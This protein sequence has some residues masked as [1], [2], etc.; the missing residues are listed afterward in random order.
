[1]RTTRPYTLFPLALGRPR[2]DSS[3]HQW[4]STAPAIKASFP[5]RPEVRLR[6]RRFPGE[7]LAKQPPRVNPCL[8]R[9]LE[10]VRPAPGRVPGAMNRG[11][12]AAASE[13]LEGHRDAIH[14]I[15][16]TGRRW[17]I[18]EH[19]AEVASASAAQNFGANHAQAGI[20]AFEHRVVDGLPEARPSGATV[21][22]GF[23]GVEVQRAARAA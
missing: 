20:W 13:R 16:Q 14:A 2:S 4:R 10:S 18:V 21:E 15:A 7:C 3:P 22:L 1:M 6:R 23:R 11:F 8:R 17:S 12:A 9:S 19:V 5:Q